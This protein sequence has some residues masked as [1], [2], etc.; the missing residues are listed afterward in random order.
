MKFD[1][2]DLVRVIDISK[3]ASTYSWMLNQIGRVNA[4]YV[5][6]EN[7]ETYHV[8]FGPNP[9]EWDKFHVFSAAD[10]ELAYASW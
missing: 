1:K 9:Y 7:I 3:K 8:Y 5:S 10:L 6:D 2:D 4:S